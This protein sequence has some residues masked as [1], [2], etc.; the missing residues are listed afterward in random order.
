MVMLLA[1]CLM[2]AA[3]LV[4]GLACYTTTGSAA[5]DE[6]RGRAAEGLR[7]ARR[8]LELGQLK[9]ELRREAARARRELRDELRESA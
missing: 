8:R 7:A 4:A 2:V 9:A 6:V 5:E 3:G 1:I